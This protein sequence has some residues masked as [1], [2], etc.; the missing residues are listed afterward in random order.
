VHGKDYSGVRARPA[1]RCTLPQEKWAVGLRDNYFDPVSQR[2]AA[3]DRR[4]RAGGGRS[5]GS[6]AGVYQPL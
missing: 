6:S 1:H 2:C 5:P 4:L 3:L